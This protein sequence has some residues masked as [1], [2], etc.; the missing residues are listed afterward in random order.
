MLLP[1]FSLIRLEIATNCISIHTLVHPWPR[2]RMEYGKRRKRWLTAASMLAISINTTNMGL[3]PFFCTTVPQ[4][5]T[6][7]TF[8]FERYDYYKGSII[9][10]MLRCFAAA[11][12]LLGTITEANVLH[13]KIL[14]HC[15][16]IYGHKSTATLKIME[17][18]AGYLAASRRPDLAR[19]YLWDVLKIRYR[20]RNSN[21]NL[22]W[23]DKL[24]E[25]LGRHCSHIN[26]E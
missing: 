8:S 1:S 11:Y 10:E 3:I 17:V 25:I 20:V 4:I 19:E 5:A 7:L 23:L 26:S 24:Q 2:D 15:T 13:S 21:G 14:N 12:R 22:P 6:C 16:K 18:L 9:L